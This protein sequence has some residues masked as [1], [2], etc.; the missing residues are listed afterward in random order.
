MDTLLDAAIVDSLLEPALPLHYQKRQRVELDYLRSQATELSSTL[1]KLTATKDTEARQTTN[2]WKRAARSQKL[3]AKKACLENTRLK[4]GLQDQLELAGALEKLLVK[5]P[6]L[7]ALPLMD[8]ADWKLR[9][10]PAE[11]TCRA[12]AFHAMM[13][14]AFEHLETMWIRTGILDVEIGQ[15]SL[16]VTEVD[17]AIRVSAKSASTVQKDFLSCSDVIWSMWQGNIVRQ[18]PHVRMQHTEQFGVNGLYVQL[19]TSYEP[20]FHVPFVYIMYAIKR[21]VYEDRVVFVLK[22]ALEDELH[23]PPPGQLIGNHS[24]SALP[25]PLKASTAVLALVSVVRVRL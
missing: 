20:A 9:R 6:R 10:L 19:S 4:R 2:Y 15:R 7:A 21:F 12:A 8:V 24:A 23:P 25:R 11:P 14:D 1:D 13:E 16:N 22:T 18:M 5:R 3:A 17:D